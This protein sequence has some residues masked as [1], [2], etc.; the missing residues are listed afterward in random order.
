LKAFMNGVFMLRTYIVIMLACF[1]IFNYPLFCCGQSGITYEQLLS[2]NI[3]QG[4]PEATYRLELEMMSEGMYCYDLP[5]FDQ[6]WRSK[7]KQILYS[8]AYKNIDKWKNSS[9][10]SYIQGDYAVIY[11][12]QNLSAGPVFAYRDGRGWV[13]DRTAVINYIHYSTDNSRWFAYG[14]DYPYLSLL[15]S[16][17]SMK[18]V[19]LNGGIQA[20]MTE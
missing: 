6:A 9:F 15:K 12:P 16:V 5:I 11:Y 18:K 1:M 13:L 4:T 3:P 20:Y 17:F 10:T 2:K 19:T 7:G 14:G 8:S